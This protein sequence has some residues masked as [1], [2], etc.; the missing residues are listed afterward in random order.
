MNIDPE[1]A[2]KV[3]NMTVEKWAG[4]CYGI[5]SSFVQS[6]LLPE[7]SVAVYGHWVGPVSEDSYF[8][9]R[10][11][12]PFVQ[13]GW[14]ALPDGR[15]CDPTRFAFEAKNPYVY[16]GKS[17]Y[18]DEG[19]NTMRRYTLR[20]C[21]LPKQGH[22]EAQ[23]ALTQLHD[24]LSEDALVLVER[25]IP[26]EPP[27]TAHQVH[28][29]ANVPLE[30]L[31]DHAHEVFEAISAL[32]LGGFIPIDNKRKAAREHLMRTG[33][34]LGKCWNCNNDCGPDDYCSGCG[35]YICEDCTTNFDLVGGHDVEDH[36]E[37][38]GIDD[39]EWDS[40]EWSYQDVE[41]GL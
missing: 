14:C 40:E 30:M 24:K 37:D 26:S 32:R 17:D 3:I 29:L 10:A 18:Y 7:G 15:V 27:W 19:G 31:E 28:W 41:A 2:A 16:I 36:L 8:G 5:A 20:P 38:S 22:N 9:S 1:Q 4:R 11:G 6:G 34:G 35:E 13:H 23:N 39:S 33:P 12:H 25:L 21:P